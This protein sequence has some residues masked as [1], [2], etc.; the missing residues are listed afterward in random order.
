MNNYERTAHLMIP[1]LSSIL[2]YM[3]LPATWIRCPLLTVDI[4]DS[5]SM[6]PNA[7]TL[8][9]SVLVIIS[10]VFWSLYLKPH[11]NFDVESIID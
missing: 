7:A 2:P 8:C 4:T 10:S 5:L 6:G 11:L 9:Q 1:A 3:I